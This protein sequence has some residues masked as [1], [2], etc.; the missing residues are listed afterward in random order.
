M[1]RESHSCFYSAH[2]LRQENVFCRACSLSAQVAQASNAIYLSAVSCQIAGVL[3]YATCINL[4][5]R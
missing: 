4:G 3:F 2:G 1:N 5:F